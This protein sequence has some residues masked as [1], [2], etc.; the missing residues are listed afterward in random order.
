M[1]AGRSK[2]WFFRFAHKG[3]KVRLCHFPSQTSVRVCLALALWIKLAH[4]EPPCTVYLHIIDHPHTHTHCTQYKIL[5]KKWLK[6]NSRLQNFLI[7]PPCIHTACRHACKGQT[8]DLHKQPH[9]HLQT[10]KPT[11]PLWLISPMCPCL[12]AH[13]H[14][15]VCLQQKQIGSVSVYSSCWVELRSLRRMLWLA[16]P[17]LCFINCLSGTPVRPGDK[18]VTL[19]SY[20]TQ[21]RRFVWGKKTFSSYFK[22]HALRYNVFCHF[23]CLTQTNAGQETGLGSDHHSRFWS[24]FKQDT[25]SPA[26]RGVALNRISPPRGGGRKLFLRRS[27]QYYICLPI[28]AMDELSLNYYIPVFQWLGKRDC[29]HMLCG[30]S[31]GKK[32]KSGLLIRLLL[33][34]PKGTFSWRAGRGF[35]TEGTK[36]RQRWQ[37]NPCFT[38]ITVKHTLTCR[39]THSHTIMKLLFT[40]CSCILCGR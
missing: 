36:D 39:C 3:N 25:E 12:C 26:P 32:K 33:S 8:Q 13:M 7:P 31:G 4:A 20:W 11:D 17:F 34:C 22:V 6:T 24:G 35:K 14:A 15:C 18:W 10:V 16:S 28:A 30:F 2:A 5:Y 37:R 1:K 38:E 29:T 9:T 19:D 21:E 27:I 23:I 40:C